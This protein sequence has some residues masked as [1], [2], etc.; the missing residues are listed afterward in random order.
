[1]NNDRGSAIMGRIN[2]EVALANNRDV[3][4]FEA[5][6]LPADK[7]RR[8]R[9]AGLVDT[10]ASYLVLPE[11]VAN[12]LGLPDLG[13]ASVRYADQQKEIR[14]VVDQVEVELLGRRGTFKA[15][16]EPARTD[17]LI[18]AIVLEDLDLLVDCRTQTLQPRDPKQI[19]AEIE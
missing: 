8:A 10:G 2:V 17:A 16:V 1:M 6:S 15:V 14:R 19:V 18:G 5:G 4:T 11:S 12:Q 13:T 3:Q 7:V 9:L